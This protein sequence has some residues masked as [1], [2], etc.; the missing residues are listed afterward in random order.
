[1]LGDDVLGQLDEP[2]AI[3]ANAYLGAEPIVAALAAGADVV[4]TGR[5][6]DASLFAGPIMHAHGW[7]PTD[8]HLVGVALGVGHLLECAGQIT[9]GYFAE[10]GVK[11]VAGLATLGFPLAEVGRDGSVVITKLPDTG[12]TVD[13][14]TCTEQL[15]YEVHDPGAYLA[16]DGVADFSN[17][18]FDQ[19]G[20]DR[21]EIRGDGSAAA[22][23]AQG[24]RRLRRWL[25]RRGRDLV[26]RGG[27]VSSAPVWRSRSCRNVLRASAWTSPICGAN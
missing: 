15:L 9:G 14:R 2:G 17:V 18:A 1:M 20:P 22:R 3:S 23:S 13:V 19:I 7:A 24:L 4:V 5:V 11:D 10:P 6:A 26:H 16:P 27:A 25:H 12:G 21:V 8:W